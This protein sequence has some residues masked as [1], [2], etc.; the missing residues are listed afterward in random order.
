MRISK[1]IMTVIIVVSCLFGLFACGTKTEQEP[2]AESISV[3]E[4]GGEDIMENI[5]EEKSVMEEEPVLDDRIPMVM[6]DGVLYLDTGE[7][8]SLAVRC[9]MMDGEITSTVDASETPTENNQSNFGSGYGYQY[10]EET[11]IEIYMNEK[12]WVFR[13]EEK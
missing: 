12:W 1:R 13:A 3:E 2:I 5:V 10:G 8:S 9:G 11:T 6:V 7:E 4:A